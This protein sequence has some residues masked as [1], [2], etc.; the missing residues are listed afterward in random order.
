M[1]FLTPTKTQ[2]LI[3]R[4]DNIIIELILMFYYAT[5][6]FLTENIIIKNKPA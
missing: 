2:G 5:L 6:L 1:I 4:H 3:D